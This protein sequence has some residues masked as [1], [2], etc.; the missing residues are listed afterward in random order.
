[1]KKRKIF[2]RKIYIYIYQPCKK[3]ANKNHEA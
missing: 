1:M 3:E 2:D